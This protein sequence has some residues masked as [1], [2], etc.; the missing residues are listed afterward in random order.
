MRGFA[1]YLGAMTLLDMV[2]LYL[3]VYPAH[4]AAGPLG[5]GQAPEAVRHGGRRSGHPPSLQPGDRGSVRMSVLTRAYHG[6]NDFDFP[7]WSR[8]MLVVSAV[9]VI[10]SIVS[11]FTRG[12][13][14]SLEFEGGSTWAV[15]SQDFSNERR[16]SRCSKKFDAAEGAKF[17]AATTAD[18]TRVLRI[19][20]QVDDVEH[21]LRGRERP[22]RRGG[23]RAR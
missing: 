15:E 21:R 11:L 10:I 18:G 14:L 9:L 22:R 5:T 4:G 23:P 3:F 17:Q 8:R 20:S 2:F 7:R 1:F 19:T 16:G 6:Q 13:T 12:L